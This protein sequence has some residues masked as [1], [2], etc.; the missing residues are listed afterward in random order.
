MYNTSYLISNGWL[1]L[2]VMKS[3]GENIC[4]EIDGK[5]LNILKNFYKTLW[6]LHP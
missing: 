4:C 1:L 2:I 5:I 3:I 6:F